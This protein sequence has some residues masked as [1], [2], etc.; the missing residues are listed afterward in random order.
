MYEAANVLLVSLSSQSD[1]LLFAA[2]TAAASSDVLVEVKLSEGN[3][4]LKV[5][6]D[7]IVV[8]QMLLKD[9]KT[10]LARV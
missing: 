3:A 5:N 8:G 4:A 6:C 7:K 2:R 9:L 1:T 10:V